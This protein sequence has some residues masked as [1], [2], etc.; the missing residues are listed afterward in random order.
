MPFPTQQQQLA[1]QTEGGARPSMLPPFISTNQLPTPAINRPPSPASHTPLSSQAPT[2]FSPLGGP[3]P[4]TM[5]SSSSNGGPSITIGSAGDT[6]ADLA[7]AAALRRAKM[8][9]ARANG[10]AAPIATPV[11][12]PSETPQAGKPYLVPAFTSRCS[13]PH[14]WA[15]SPSTPN[16]GLLSPQSTFASPTSRINHLAQQLE[17]VRQSASSRNMNRDRYA[18]AEAD[19]RELRVLEV[20]LENTIKETMAALAS[21]ANE[22]LESQNTPATDDRSGDLP[23]PGG[24]DE[25]GTG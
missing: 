17:Q 15:S 13:T 23:S 5:A 22:R 3:G 8:M 19:L 21:S 20:T 6:M 1:G 24:G 2:V 11:D 4:S 25:T 7:R 18:E 14:P 16:P 9:E 12:T 10:N